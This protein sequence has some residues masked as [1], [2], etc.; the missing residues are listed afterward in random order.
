[1]NE[2]CRQ[3]IHTVGKF[4]DSRNAKNSYRRKK[5]RRTAKKQIKIRKK[6]IHFDKAFHVQI[7]TT[8]LNKKNERPT[9]ATMSKKMCKMQHCKRAL[10]FHCIYG[11]PILQFSIV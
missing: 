4:S 2:Q 5:K 8:L 9:A 3:S 11:L 7:P 1:M 6:K 10:P